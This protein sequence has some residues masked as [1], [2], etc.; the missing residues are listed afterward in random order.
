VGIAGKG[1]W[2][3]RQI[4]GEDGDFVDFEIPAENTWKFGLNGTILNVE[5]L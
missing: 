2:I 4:L 3:C 5:T 1:R